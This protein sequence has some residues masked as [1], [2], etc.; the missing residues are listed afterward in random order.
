LTNLKHTKIKKMSKKELVVNAIKEGTVIDH[1]PAKDL[2]KVIRILGLECSDNQIT[3]GTNLKSE[4]LGKKAIIKIE[5]RFFE[6][7]EINKIALV[8]QDANLNIIKD[9]KVV[10]K[11]MVEI[12]DKVVGIV[13]CFNPKCITNNEPVTTKFTV[14]SKKDV[15]L[16]CC[17]CEKITDKEHIEIK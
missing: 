17:Y 5:N 11:M 14:V 3:F 7:E 10:N 8:A 4:K 2:F 12:P 13:K 15:T 6:Q 1:I 16:K 9:Y